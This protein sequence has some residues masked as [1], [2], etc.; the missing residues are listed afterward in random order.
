MRK[1]SIVSK[2]FLNLFRNLAIF[3]PAL[4]NKIIFKP[5]LETDRYKI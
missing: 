2:L 5:N 1:K 4:K 3:K